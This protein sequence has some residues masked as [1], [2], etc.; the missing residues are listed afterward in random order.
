MAESSKKEWGNRSNKGGCPLAAEKEPFHGVGLKSEGRQPQEEQPAKI[1]VLSRPLEVRA[2]VQES[3]KGSSL[4]ESIK[5]CLGDRI[6]R[7]E[8]CLP[9]SGDEAHLQ[10][11]TA[12][13]LRL[14]LTPV[15]GKYQLIPHWLI[16]LF[17]L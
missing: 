2:P 10:D 4:R 12:C 14:F 13:F 15:P 9:P 6:P 7:P 11:H 5:L 17:S 16:T 8:L 1:L 3:A